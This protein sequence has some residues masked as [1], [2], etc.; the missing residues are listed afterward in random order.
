VDRL[1]VITSYFNPAGFHRRLT[2]YRAFRERISAPLLTVELSFGGG[3]ALASSDADVLV[4]LCG[5]DVMWQKDDV[6]KRKRTP[7]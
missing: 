5:G 2:N 4:Q 6:V 3:F 1:W 7:C